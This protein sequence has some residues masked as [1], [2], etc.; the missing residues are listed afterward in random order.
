MIKFEFQF[1]VEQFLRNHLG[2][3]YIE[4][5]HI[6]TEDKPSATFLYWVLIRFEICGTVIDCNRNSGISLTMKTDVSY[7]HNELLCFNNAGWDQDGTL[8]LPDD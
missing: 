2:H 7:S 5:R 4:G 1:R 6:T 8:L 3:L